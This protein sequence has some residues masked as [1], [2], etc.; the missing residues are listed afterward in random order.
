MDYLINIIKIAIALSIL[1]VWLFRFNKST[2]WRGN[3]ADTMADEFKAYGLPK[4]LM[5]CVGS[6]KVLFSI[7]LLVSFYYTQLEI[8]SALGITVLM[9]GAI[10]MHLKIGDPIKKSLPAFIFLSLS[11]IVA[12]VQ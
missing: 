4:W 1:N 8:P 2:A 11:L 9:F 12:L 7:G 3:N 6:L 5:L 10:L